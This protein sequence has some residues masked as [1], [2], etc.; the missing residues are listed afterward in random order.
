MNVLHL[1][2][3]MEKGGAETYLINLIKNSK[4]NVKYFIVCDHKGYNHRK[5]E[6]LDVEVEIIPMNSV[7]D[8]K[9]AHKIASYCKKNKIDIIQAHFLR[10]SFI[11]VLAKLFYP[12]LRVVWTTHFI[13]EYSGLINKLNKVFAKFADRIISVSNAVKKSLENENINS[14]KITTIYNGVDTEYF[15]PIAVNNI[16]EEFNID[17]DE[18]LLITAARFE[19]I[20]GHD[21]LIDGLYEL[22]NKGIQ[23]KCLLVGDGSE[24]N[25]LENKIKELE[26]EENIIFTGYREDIPSLLSASDIYIS[27][28]I[29]EA[30]SFSILEALSCNIPAIATNVGGV[31]E[32]FEQ[33]NCGA[34]IEYGDKEALA[35]SILELYSNK[36]EYL[37][38]KKNAR[39]LVIDKFSI[40]NMVEKTVE[41]Y[42]NSIS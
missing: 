41:L 38:K 7:Y 33:S 42:E 23:F 27:P 29:N 30:I 31:P 18:L 24:K 22:K 16:R 32:I 37:E 39:K 4:E 15:K 17:K 1:I 11:A 25:N 12:K 3:S 2:F 34:M 10:E 6:E 14:K 20:K 8:I 19:K 36:D 28:S 26:L 9:S 35:N 40:T 5:L 21:F 13:Y